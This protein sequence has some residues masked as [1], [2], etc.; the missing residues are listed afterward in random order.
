MNSNAE[1]ESASLFSRKVFANWFICDQFISNW[2]KSKGFSIIKDRILKDENDIRRRVY[3]CEHRKKHTFRSSKGTSSKKI[4]CSWHVNVSCPKTDN[5][6]SAIFINK[7]V[8][9]HNHDLNIE[10]VAFRK[11][12]VFNNEIIEDI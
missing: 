8:D 7:I 10:L 6:N 12:K 5:S 4:Q 9:E 2:S 1:T 11:N 3:I